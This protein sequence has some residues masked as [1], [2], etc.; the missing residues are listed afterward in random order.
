VTRI[1]FSPATHVPDLTIISASAPLMACPAGIRREA[2][3]VRNTR[4]RGMR[5][6]TGLAGIGCLVALLAACGGGSSGEGLPASG[7]ITLSSSTVSVTAARGEFA[8]SD[9]IFVTAANTGKKDLF[10]EVHYSTIGITDVY[11]D[12]YSDNQLRIAIYFRHPD[13]MEI[14]EY[15]DN[16][17]VKVCYD[18]PCTQQVGGSPATVSVSYAVTGRRYA[19]APGLPALPVLHQ[20]KLT[21]N[22]ID[23]EYSNALD[24][25]VMVSSSP[26]SALHVFDPV[27]GQTH[28]V[29]LSKEPTAVSLSPG[30]LAAAV[31]HDGLISHVDLA[32]LVQ[33]GATTP[34]HLDVSTDVF[35][36]VL[37]GRGFV[38]AFPGR[39]LSSL[40]IRSIEIA[41][42]LE[43]LGGRQEE[44]RLRGRLHPV[45]DY[46]YAIDTYFSRTD[47]EKYE[48]ST[49][50][51]TYLYR[52]SYDGEHET[53]GRL[54]LKEDGQAIYTACGNTFL[55]SGA[56]LEDMA[57][58]GQLELSRPGHPMGVRNVVHL[59]QSDEMKEIML[60]DHEPRWCQLGFVV[61][62]FTRLAL[63]ESD[64]LNRTALY[65]VA[66]LQFD[67]DDHFQDGRFVFHSA[68]GTRRYLVSVVPTAP[69]TPHFV[70]VLQ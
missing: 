10:V 25:I 60:I 22:V 41:T 1:A 4:D 11:L 28:T 15:L 3:G 31:G 38:H 17:L 6:W 39:E 20:T 63:Y 35:D 69:G 59:S 44:T 33:A 56:Y 40:G 2:A 48:V 8:P 24:A 67:G 47:I 9:R 19:D 65:S 21:H 66:P 52:S 26:A 5:S 36:I 7:S 14:G 64:S 45:G 27:S 46:I 13:E 61:P 70:S 49:G 29:A 32:Q 68:D 43:Q 58:L 50:K 51:A 23:A 57:Y 16:M 37:D 42:N 55:A 30:G 53:C 34:L 62:C 18:E 12:M 54:W